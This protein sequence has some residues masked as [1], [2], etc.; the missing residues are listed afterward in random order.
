MPGPGVWSRTI[1]PFPRPK[2]A[3]SSES[4]GSPVNYGL[5]EEEE[6]VI[7]KRM[8]AQCMI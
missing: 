8:E 7:V 6:V 4:Q 5:D 2:S 1:H 3:L